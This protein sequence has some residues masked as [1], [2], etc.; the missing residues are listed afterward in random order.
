[1]TLEET[2][3]NLE[4]LGFQGFVTIGSLFKNSSVLPKVRGVYMILYPSAIAP[5][6]RT[7]GSGGHFK[8]KNP[9]VSL[10]L[11]QDNWVDDATIVYIGK[12]GS[13][14]GSATLQ[15]RLK[16]Y[17]NFGQGKAVGHW[18]GRLIWQLA[19]ADELVVCWK[20]TPQDEP[21]F[22]ESNLIKKFKQI[23]GQRPFSNLK[24]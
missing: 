11:L 3:T 7:I 13:E 22:V 18:G 9:N 24:D 6:F 2:K 20:I 14:S 8:E 17:L 19:L 23:Y 12:A 5:K 16:Q 1:M 10:Q 21:A 4:E 15:S